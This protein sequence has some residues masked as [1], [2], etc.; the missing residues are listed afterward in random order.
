MLMTP[1][2]RPDAKYPHT[3]VTAAKT[4]VTL[5]IRSA[6]IPIESIRG[7]DIFKTSDFIGITAILFCFCSIYIKPPHE[8]PSYLKSQ[9]PDSPPGSLPNSLSDSLPGSLSGSLKDTIPSLLS[10]YGKS[11]LN[12]IPFYRPLNR[13]TIRKKASN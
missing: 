11:C 8:L 5:I 6:G 13:Q 1:L 10:D 12:P 3:M 2:P 7:I 9:K 4:N